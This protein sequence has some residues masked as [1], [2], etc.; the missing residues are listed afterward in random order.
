MSE[1]RFLR[2]AEASFPRMYQRMEQYREAIASKELIF[3]CKC[4]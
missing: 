3:G 2:D 1:S 4:N